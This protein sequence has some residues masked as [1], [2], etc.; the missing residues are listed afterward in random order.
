MKEYI[1][2]I[3]KDDIYDSS[4]SD[5]I[6]KVKKLTKE[7]ENLK[8]QICSLK[9]MNEKLLNGNYQIKNIADETKI[10]KPPIKDEYHLANSR[11]LHLKDKKENET[12]SK[13][14]T[15]SSNQEVKSG[16]TQNLNEDKIKDKSVIHSKEEIKVN[17]SSS[18]NKE[19]INS[20]ALQQ[21]SKI[22]VKKDNKR[23]KAS[24]FK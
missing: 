6:E 14:S 22:I 4:K 20:R 13:Q 5:L 2:I 12:N 15:F 11:F 3:T 23:R 8:E 21:H 9:E 19:K 24:S 10:I 1:A 18:Q 16:D 17:E 7:N